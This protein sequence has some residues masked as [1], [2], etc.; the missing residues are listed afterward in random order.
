MSKIGDALARVRMDE[1]SNA[2]NL[3]IAL[4]T[5][6]ESHPDRPEDDEETDCGW[7]VWVEEM[8]DKAIERLAQAVREVE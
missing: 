1:T 7:G 8:C 6:F 2:D 4:C 3:A 5:Y